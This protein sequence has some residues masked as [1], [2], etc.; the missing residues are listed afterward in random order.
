MKHKGLR[1]GFVVLN[2]AVLY[3]SA[4]II[5]PYIFIMPRWEDKLTIDLKSVAIYP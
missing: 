3:T 5:Y 2:S 1:Q 4:H